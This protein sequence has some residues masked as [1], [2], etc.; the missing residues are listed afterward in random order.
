MHVGQLVM[1][2]IDQ[3]DPGCSVVICEVCRTM[4]VYSL[5][6]VMCN[7]E[8]SIC[9]YQSKLAVVTLYDVTLCVPSVNCAIIVDMENC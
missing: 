8:S 3:E 2:L 6:V 1:T 7:K 9:S 4:R 5:L